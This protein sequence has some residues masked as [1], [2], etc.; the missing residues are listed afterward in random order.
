MTKKTSKIVTLPNTFE[1]HDK[2]DDGRRTFIYLVPTDT[3]YIAPNNAYHRDIWDWLSQNKSDEYEQLWSDR[4]K[5]AFKEGSVVLGLFDRN[6]E[7]HSL[8]ARTYWAEGNDDLPDHIIN[9]LSNY[10]GEK[11]YVRPWEYPVDWTQIVDMPD[12]HDEEPT[13]QWP[14]DSLDAITHKHN[15]MAESLP[16]DEHMAAGKHPLRLVEAQPG[17]AYRT[18]SG[19]ISTYIP[20]NGDHVWNVIEDDPEY[21]QEFDEPPII[22]SINYHEKTDGEIHVE[23]IFVDRDYRNTNAF[24][25]LAQPL[26]ALNKP[27]SA[28][29]ANE[30][31]QDVFVKL[32]QRRKIPVSPSFEPASSDDIRSLHPQ[33]GFTSSLHGYE[34]QKEAGNVEP[35]DISSLDVVKDRNNFAF[36]Y[37][38][39]TLYVG[40][41][42]RRIINAVL[43]QEA[44]RSTQHAVFGWAD[45]TGEWLDDPYTD[46]RIKI[47]SG[48]FWYE[49][50]AR[51]ELH[52]EALAAVRQFVENSLGEKVAGVQPVELM[53]D[54]PSGVMYW[55]NGGGTG[56]LSR[57]RTAWA[58]RDGSLYVGLNH[59]DI[60]G[61]M[62]QEGIDPRYNTLYGWIDPVGDGKPWATVTDTGWQDNNLLPQVQA[63]FK[64]YPPQ[65]VLNYIRTGELTVPPDLEWLDHTGEE[66]ITTVSTD[67]ALPPDGS[68]S[69]EFFAFLYD[70]DKDTLLGQWGGIH[71]ILGPLFVE[72]FGDASPRTVFGWM[73]NGQIHRHGIED[74]SPELKERVRALAQE[75]TSSLWKRASEVEFVSTRPDDRHGMGLPWMYIPNH[76]TL[77]VG[78]TRDFHRELI[79]SSPSIQDH[80]HEQEY[81]DYAH[82]ADDYLAGR[83]DEKGNA[84]IYQ[85]SDIAD[86]Y[87]DKAIEALREYYPEIKQYIDQLEPDIDLLENSD[88]PMVNVA[89]WEEPWAQAWI[90]TPQDDRLHTHDTWHRPLLGYIEHQYGYD[91]DDRDTYVYGWYG[92]NA[93][94]NEPTIYSDNFGGNIDPK[95]QERAKDKANQWLADYYQRGDKNRSTVNALNHWAAYKSPAWVYDPETDRFY[96]GDFHR[97]II[98]DND[99]RDKFAPTGEVGAWSGEFFETPLVLGLYDPDYMRTPEISSDYG[100]SSATYEQQ[101]RGLALAMK[102]YMGAKLAGVL[103]IGKTAKIGWEF[104]GFYFPQSNDVLI[105][106]PGEGHTHVLKENN[107]TPKDLKSREFVPFQVLYEDANKAWIVRTGSDWVRGG[108]WDWPDNSFDTVKH[109]LAVQYHLDPSDIYNEDEYE[110]AVEQGRLG[111]TAGDYTIIEMTDPLYM[112]DTHGDDDRPFFALPDGTILVGV[113]G[114]YHLDLMHYAREVLGVS[115]AQIKYSSSAGFVDSKGKIHFVHESAIDPQVVQELEEAGYGWS[116]APRT[117][118]THVMYHGSPRK[119]R[120]S[121]IDGLDVK[122]DPWG[123]VNGVDY[124][125]EYGGSWYVPHDIPPERV[126]LLNSSTRENKTATSVVE[127]EHNMTAD[128]AGN[129]PANGR[130]AWVYVPE[131]DTIY[132]VF[133]DHHK[134]L[135]R[136]FKKEWAWDVVAGA[137]YQGK[138]NILFGNEDQL[139]DDAKQALDAIGQNVMALSNSSVGENTANVIPKRWLLLKDGDVQWSEPGEIQHR[140]MIK[141]LGLDAQSIVAGGSIEGDGNVNVHFKLP[142]ISYDQVRRMIKAGSGRISSIGNKTAGYPGRWIK[143]IDGTVYVDKERS[144]LSHRQMVKD[145]GIDPWQIDTAGWRDE[146]FYTRTNPKD[147]AYLTAIGKNATLMP[148]EPWNDPA[149]LRAEQ[150]DDYG[151]GD[152]TDIEN[153]YIPFIVLEDGRHW[154]GWDAHSHAYDWMTEDAEQ[155]LGI[156]YYDM[157]DSQGSVNFA[158]NEYEVHWPAHGLHK[159]LQPMIEAKIVAAVEDERKRTYEYKRRENT[160]ASKWSWRRK[161]HVHAWAYLPD[162]DELVAG[163]DHPSLVA[164]EL[165]Q[166]AGYDPS[167]VAQIMDGYYESVEPMVQAYY[168][169]YDKTQA[170]AKDHALFGWTTNEGEPYLW[171]ETQGN[172]ASLLNSYSEKALT[173]ARETASKTARGMAAHTSALRTRVGND[174]DGMYLETVANMDALQVEIL[175]RLSDYEPFYRMVFL[176]HPDGRIEIGTP[177]VHNDHEDLGGELGAE[178]NQ[179]FRT[180]RTPEEAEDHWFNE[181]PYQGAANS[182]W[183]AQ[184]SV[185]IRTIIGQQHCQ[186][187]GC[188]EL[189]HQTREVK[190]QASVGQ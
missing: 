99:L 94:T 110:N 158:S 146:V 127:G 179:K 182:V 118:A 156:N 76:D 47:M 41:N 130:A 184:V 18:W 132:W 55:A 141:R 123:E 167:Q 73:R 19:G 66:R 136:T 54:E 68:G 131:S 128:D 143:M 138:N 62:R 187:H 11:V 81:G 2:Y 46:W 35:A 69:P 112:D 6:Y 58:Y 116:S 105:G 14:T 82:P 149:W 77:Y 97:Q 65:A 142:N 155:E 57:A 159:E 154:I 7:D 114:G 190:P 176:Y 102:H 153:P 25:M 144:S 59:R 119:N 171:S 165:S 75:R 135:A 56:E 4:F 16:S 157:K 178:F 60:M 80:M 108:R 120:E 98:H 161:D 100:K 152:H 162:T 140:E 117:T 10:M 160:S 86:V 173:R 111:K 163:A 93:D 45:R 145:L 84:T 38:D 104:S 37:L 124:L 30:R 101:N 50:D 125:T 150:G 64:Q 72:N 92:R 29:F 5:D 109:E 147:V 39:G 88:T 71:R 22:G 96:V 8:E 44:P 115:N 189:A 89:S 53:S 40:S 166:R 175:E 126:R 26:L 3:L 67:L 23:E 24:Y 139:P 31:L 1:P 169:M 170:W 174:E 121:I 63:F 113:P 20:G 79:R 85:L 87:K 51:P 91:P 180:F 49:N 17:D 43:G 21:V 183:Y 148:N 106:F 74:V 134:A 52:D 33:L 13:K 36:M 177:D 103:H 107:M 168:E 164:H 70:P 27:I 181:P 83:I 42:H 48:S 186:A 133:N 172:D 9:E 90:Y 151:Y 15:T 28:D 122:P 32:W 61:S 12:Y 137:F 129:D 78:T 95:V 185:Q 34:Q 188:R